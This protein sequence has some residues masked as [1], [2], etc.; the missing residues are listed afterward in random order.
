MKPISVFL[1]LIL[2]F[3][4]ACN[5]QRQ[6][7]TN[8]VTL[9]NPFVGTD[10]HGH[11]FPGATVPFGMVQLS[12][13]THTE[14]WDWCSGYHY[15]DSSI[16]GFSHTHLSGTGRGE[17]LDIL[18]MPTTGEIQFEAGT[19]ENPDAGYRS[20]FSHANEKAAPGYYS[21]LLDDYKIRAE[22]TTTR[23]VGFHR[24]TFSE[25]KDANVIFDLGHSLKSDSIYGGAIRVVG[26]SMLVGSR[27]SR[28]WGEGQE[29]FWV[30][31]EVFFAAKFSQPITKNTFFTDGKILTDQQQ[32]EGNNLKAALC[33]DVEKEKHL[34][35]KVGISSVSVEGAVNNLETEIGHW[36]FDQT[37]TKAEKEWAEILNLFEI[38]DPDMNKKECFYTAVY[39]ACI[40]PFT[41]SDADKKY[42]GY[43]REIHRA[44]DFTMLT[45]L[46]LWDTF[47][48][49]NPLYTLIAPDIT[50]DMIHSM[51]AQYDQYGL[52]PVWPLYN[53]ETNCM[54]GYHSVPVIVDAYFKG[55]RGFDIEKAYIAMKHSAMQDDFGIQHLK[56]YNYIPSDLENKS[57]SK[58]L[59]YAFDDW[60]LAQLAKELGKDD[61]YDYFM[62]RSQAY[63]NVFDPASKFM[64]DRNSK[65]LFT[66]IFDP[67]FSSYGYSGFIEGNSWQYSWFVPH[68]I[69]GLVEL[70]GG[71]QIFSEKLDQLF[72]TTTSNHEN[73]PIDITGLIGEYAHG[74]EPSHHV[75]YLYSLVGQPYKTQEKV[76][77][78]CN[79][80]YSNKPDGLCGN[81]DMGQMSAWYIFSALG[82]YPVNPAN[83]QYVLGTPAFQRVTFKLPN[84]KIL[85]IEA[86][87]SSDKDF[88][89]KSVY[90]NGNMVDQPFVTHQQLL[91]GGTLTFNILPTLDN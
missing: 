88:L 2:G 79:E 85:K 6:V 86:N 21:I 20:R 41:A 29:K 19:R 62:K 47:R 61:D 34:L 43:D 22:L 11:T 4:I 64:R 80:L 18:V 17:A 44:E 68:D 37:A 65:G 87:R 33:F 76:H 8:V 57:V 45:G 25:N 31:H 74:N 3:T 36:D 39:H 30:E 54:I 38:E 58:T 26:D 91:E 42:M 50:R 89:V 15:S 10:G 49:A 52:L 32:A 77:Q 63:R 90:L 23:R 84:G 72:S 16:I 67:T 46:S 82:F 14:G 66:E 27:K 56:K 69:D 9:V 83:G 78:I 40:A 73:K 59:E 48:A 1:I 70:M 35:L 60:C 13:D 28:G 24:Y 81:E 71:T 5:H 51:L 53:S 75:A 55:I 7:E 12:P